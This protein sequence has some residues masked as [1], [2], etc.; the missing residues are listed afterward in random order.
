N[1]AGSVGWNEDATGQ[2]QATNLSVDWLRRFFKL[3]L[4]IDGNLDATAAITGNLQNPQARGNVALRNASLNRT[5]IQTAEATF[6]YADARLGVIGRM[7]IRDTPPLPN[8]AITENTADFSL[9]E[10]SEPEETLP[11][12]TLPE[13]TLPGETLPEETLPEER[14]DT[15]DTTPLISLV[16]SLPYR[17]P[18]ATVDPER[19]D[20]DLNI[21]V[22]DDGIAL[23]NLLNEHF[24]WEEGQ[25]MVTLN[26][27]GTLRQLEEGIDFRPTIVGT[28]Q[29]ESATFSARVLP[30]PLT[31]VTGDVQFD[32]DRIT[33]NTFQGQFSDGN[34]SASGVIPLLAPFTP[35]E[36]GRLS[37]TPDF[38]TPPLPDSPIPPLPPP[39]RRLL[40]IDLN[41]LLVNFKGLYNGG[42][43]GR[44]TIGG[45][46][47]KPQLGGGIILSE[48]RVSLPD[49]TIVNPEATVVSELPNFWTGLIASPELTNLRVTLGKR[50]LI[51]R[52]PLLNFVATGELIVNGPL[53]TD[54]RSISPQGV[55]TLHSGQVNVFTTQ[56]NLDRSHNNVAIFTTRTGADPFLDVRLETSVL[57]ETRRSLPDDSILARPEIAATSAND[58]SQFQ[59]VRIQAAVTGPASQLFNG[60][61]L[62]SSPSRSETEI[63]TLIG[64][65]FADTLGRSE[66]F[67]GIANLAGT[68]LFTSLQTLVSNAIGFSDLRI[69]PTVITSADEDEDDIRSSS[70]LALAAE[71]GFRLTRDLS[72]SAL[73]LLT[74]NEPTQYNLRYQINDELLLR[75]ATNFSDESRIILEFETRF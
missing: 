12:E 19:D 39:D 14:T 27:G 75:G 42:V 54:L 34:F 7:Q 41:N 53:Q 46:A 74:V 36:L 37:A 25:G 35:D 18:F 10:S 16:G 71:L 48:G 62:S 33:V 57:E 23:L 70:S 30:A 52:L 65:G 38:P 68:A 17:L 1:F 50:L 56:F 9:T 51:T 4:N 8:P 43:D 29:V 49:P 26:V 11:E 58:F 32:G 20:I 45:T 5:P 6:S 61:E 2:F 69:F 44:I 63:V 64:G 47:L 31:H 15:T 3:P 59:T 67:V 24:F 60:I 28:A 22:Q 13:E 40:A 21:A 72:V 73:Q 55:I 66:G